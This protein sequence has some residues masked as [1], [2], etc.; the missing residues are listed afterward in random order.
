MAI[1]YF[2]SSALVKYFHRES[3]SEWVKAIIETRNDFEFENKVYLS[4]V[5]RVEIPAAFALLART[6]QI[7]LSARDQM[8]DA[9]AQDLRARF[10]LV[11]LTSA[12]L[13]RAA[14]LTQQHPLKAYDAV[15]L[16]SGIILSESFRAD[17]LSLTFIASD[18]TLLQAAQ[19]EGL[20]AENP[21]DH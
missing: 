12:I 17:A 21:S 20:V 18:K 2:D 16:A 11:Y 7:T 13:Q 3:G 15:Q 10:R 6:R 5:G 8:Y 19:A 14:Q 9:F 4:D 1:Y